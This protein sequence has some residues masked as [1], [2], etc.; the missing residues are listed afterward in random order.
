MK[1]RGWFPTLSKEAPSQKQSF[2]FLSFPD[3]IDTGVRYKRPTVVFAFQ[4]RKA[5]TRNRP[6]H[7][8]L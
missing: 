6:A 5:G 1:A 3:R 4:A 8:G 7:H 2:V